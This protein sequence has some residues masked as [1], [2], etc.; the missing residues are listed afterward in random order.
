MFILPFQVEFRLARLPIATVMVCVLCLG[1]FLEQRASAT[2]WH[3]AI[4]RS[5]DHA[6]ETLLWL[7]AQ[8]SPAPVGSQCRQLAA[9]L[10]RAGDA[11][12]QIAATAEDWAVLPFS[13]R[14][15]GRDGVA[16]TL[17]TY[18]EALARL[19][20]SPPLTPRLI[21]PPR[22]WNPWRMVTAALAHAGWGHLLGNLFFFYLF[23]AT[24]EAVLGSARYLGFLFGLAIGTHLVYSLASLGSAAPPTLGLS[25]VVYGVLALFAYFL[26]DARIRCVYGWL[27]R[28][29]F[30]SLSAWFVAL[31]YVGGDALSLL[32]DGNDGGVNFLAHVSGAVIAIAIGM[33]LFRHERD[34]VREEAKP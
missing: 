25:G 21:Y 5:C 26:P 4:E 15:G 22:S 20:G 19:G 31:W 12:A 23:G 10:L 27:L 17:S 32:L 34:L 9:E 3:D 8:H 13:R 28:I 24:V 7:L 14:A 30:T 2:R 16:A 29:G 33:S 6:D 18:W 11:R 1:V